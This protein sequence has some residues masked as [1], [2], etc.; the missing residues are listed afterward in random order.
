M[1]QWTDNTDVLELAVKGIAE[2]QAV[3]N[4]FHLI[5]QSA[6]AAPNTGDLN[7][8]LTNF[9]AAWRLKMLALMPANYSVSEYAV[10]AIIGRDPNPTGQPNPIGRW[11]PY[12]LRFGNQ[13]VLAGTN[14]DVG[15]RLDQPLPTLTAASVRWV[16]QL[17]FRWSRSG[18]RFFSGGE[19]DTTNNAWN[20]TATFKT[21]MADWIT[22]HLAG[23]ISDAGGDV[24]KPCVFGRTTYL[25]AAP[26]VVNPWTYTSYLAN[27]ILSP[28][29]SS[30]VSRK[31]R[32]R[33]Q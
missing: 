3:I 22:T 15:T 11:T 2:G 13:L 27:G 10:T 19:N 24:V 1:P 12:V 4:V 16:S 17:R 5:T 9:R 32:V 18:S 33:P 28:Y 21:K 14:L 20:D 7:L 25:R 8:V 26:G 23:Y 30:Q 31:Q 6:P 29:V